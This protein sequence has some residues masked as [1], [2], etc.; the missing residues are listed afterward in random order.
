MV[1]SVVEKTSVAHKETAL[2]LWFEEVGTHDVGLVGG[3]NSSLG[4]M[5]QQLTSKG[6]NVPS[7]FA[8]TAYAYRYFIQEAGL[9]QKLRDLFADLDVNNMVNLQ[10]RGHLARQL[11]L[12]TPFPQNLQ[13]AIAEAYGV[14]CERYGCKV[15]CT[16]VDVA[17]R[18]SATAE[19]LPEASFAGQQETYL[20]VHSLSCVLESCH[21][22]FASLFTDRAISY[23]HHNGFDHFAV[24]LSV[25]VQKMVRSDLAT[26]GVMFSIDTETGFKNAALITAAYGLGENVVQ[27]AVNP[28]EYFVFKPTLKEGFKPIL[29]KRLGS[30]AI[31]MVYDVGGSKLTKNVEVAEPEREKYCINDEE[32]LQLARWACIIED[33][34]SE[35]RGIYTPMD[36]EW[37]KDGQTG[38]L[39]I[40]QARPET[41]Q[42]QKS[43][44]VIKTYELKD[45]SQ[46]LATG[47]S[48]GAA[49]GQGKAQVIRNV[50]EINQFRPGE[51]LITN[52]TDPDWEPIMKQASA[53]VTNQGGRTCFAGATNILTNQ[54]FMSLKQIHTQGYD[55]LSTLSLNT[56]TQKMEW[57][58]ILDS[59]K[60]SGKIIG[61]S[62]S[63]TGK[64]V[65]NTLRL[66]P[67]HKMVNL[68][69]GKYV[70]TEIQEMLEKREMVLVSQNIPMLGDGKNKEADLA[71]F[72]G[73][74]ITDGSI[75]TSRTHGEVQF[76]QKDVPEKEAFIATMQEKATAL[77]GKSFTPYPKAVS[78]GYIRGEK[79]TGQATA[80]RLYSKAIAY[81]VQAKEQ[82]ISQI[83]L[84]NDAEVAYQFLAG[85]IDGDG[86]YGNNRIN[87]YIS[88]ENLLQA[89]IIACLKINTVP[90]VTNNRHIHN[91]QIVEKIPEILLYTRRVK[92]EVKPRTIQT[93]FFATKQL[94]DGEVKGQIKL[95]KDNNFLISDKQL[96][97]IG[98]F[99]SLLNS[100]L[101]MQRVI[102][103]EDAQTGD[104]YNITVADH[105]NYV[106]FTEKYTPVVVCNCHAAIIA[107]EMGIP[108]IVGCGDATDSIKTGED[109]TICCSEGDEGSVYSGILNYEVHETELSNIPRTKTQIL[110]NVGNPEQAFGFASY[111]ADGVGLARLEF[112]IANHI[113]AHPLAL[114]KFD[115]LEDPVAKA[116][117]A[118][119][120]KLYAGDRPQ[121]FVDKLAHGIAM[122][123]AAFYPKPVVVRMS[124]FKS[125][126]YANLLGGRQFEPKEENPMI[127]WRGA[128]RYYDPNYREAYALE[129]QALKRVRD[130]M[131]LTNV[132]PMIPFCRTPDEGRK[133]I[134][135]MAKHG[136]K[137]GENGLEIY[138]MC[139]LPSN[140]ILAD[141]FSQ[142]FDGFSIGSND[143]TQLTL[144]LDRDSS[145][146][147]HLFD[148]RNQ[149]VK[150]MVKMAIETAKANGRKIGICGQAPSDYPEFA[151]FLV[152]LGIDSIS[153]NPDSVLKTVLRIAEVEKAKPS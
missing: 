90:Q 131:G 96:Q 143:L 87:I 109:V 18:S 16:G 62:V 76:I 125:N 130:D 123:A 28:D 58:P 20:N 111:P 84:E 19:D 145:L 95:R 68:R 52:R 53:I 89:V 80:Y 134:A 40:V 63:Q 25:G 42:S 75:Y 12:D 142:V 49:I 44:N 135:E 57:K 153:L 132:I 105:H 73:G 48:V 81:E 126:E 114:M 102:Q 115:E 60:R 37:A 15:D 85:V 67:D 103:M 122:I 101:R 47:R 149:G 54:G 118:Q 151:E 86:C 3:K 110:M 77:F 148:E 65:N 50:S 17:V 146:V 137:Q 72:L 51:V 35:V 29:E 99:E 55:G 46:V 9:E 127:G 32:I 88:E 26:S 139:E 30:K 8:T 4:E 43:A 45:H 5:I 94:F 24:A 116:E 38:E 147:A 27:G 120:T 61:V 121:F 150:R 10:E 22:C 2:I 138:V 23:R 41:V 31:K 97:E 59:M 91:V 140:V 74:I 113:K 112:I 124:D 129:C 104:V 144:G 14:M 69:Q 6:V 70:K 107:R 78:S 33:H 79:V 64:T 36:I 98:Q 66:T 11:I 100:D 13:A 92:G 152:E 56:E 108:A 136:L 1:S 106:V 128:S 93:R 82:K 117:I 7:G 133:V 119:L 83:L 21:K 141:E 34:Y 71:Y 39:F